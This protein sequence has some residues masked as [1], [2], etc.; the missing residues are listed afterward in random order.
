MQQHGLQPV[1]SPTQQSGGQ[2]LHS[3]VGAA[4][5]LQ[6]N[7]I[8]GTIVISAGD[9]RRQS[10]LQHSLLMRLP[11]RVVLVASLASSSTSQKVSPCAD[12]PEGFAALVQGA[13]PVARGMWKKE[14]LQDVHDLAILGLAL[15]GL[16][17]PQ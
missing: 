4:A 7:V 11:C 12:D 6:H 17:R 10:I 15:H 3:S 16:R 2:T 13:P 9:R 14:E 8:T 1:A 5:G